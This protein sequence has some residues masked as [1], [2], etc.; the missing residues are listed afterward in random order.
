MR[1]SRF[2]FTT[3]LCFFA[4]STALGQELGKDPVKIDKDLIELTLDKL[5]KKDRFTRWSYSDKKSDPF[6]YLS[7]LYQ[8][9]T[10]TPEN[11]NNFHSDLGLIYR[12]YLVENDKVKINLQGWVEQ[13]SFWAGDPTA[14]FS[15]KTGMISSPNASSETGYDLNLENFYF[16]FFLFEQKLDITIGKFDP[17][18]LTV[19]SNYSGWDKY[20][21][22]AKSTASD[23]VPDL[24]GAMGLYSEYHITDKFSFGGLIVDNEPRNNFLYIPK[25]GETSWNY[26]GF[27]RFKF[28]GENNL[29]SDHNLAFY[30]QSVAGNNPTGNGFI[31]TGNQGLTE[32]MILVLK[33]SNGTGRIDKL[34]AAYVAGLTFKN[35]LRREAD[36]AGFALI[37]NEKDLNYEYGLDTYWRF[38]INPYLNVAPNFQAYYTVSDQINT[39]FGVRAFISY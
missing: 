37:L 25:F 14:E 13:T 20:N 23:P 35:P 10:G 17:L 2:S 12:W 30:Y 32:N 16:E 8:Y 3:L 21:Y 5:V 1:Y 29:Y 19:F 7:P 11:S 34:N 38:F 9:G 4:I 6:F 28:G 26:M 15:R 27:M 31:Y 24:D 36:Q 18:Y 22:F 33:F 39:V